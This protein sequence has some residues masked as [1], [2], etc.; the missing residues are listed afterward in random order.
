MSVVDMGDAMSLPPVWDPNKSLTEKPEA[1][2]DHQQMDDFWKGLS[3]C[4][5]RDSEPAADDPPT[6]NAGSKVIVAIGIV[7]ALAVLGKMTEEPAPE[8]SAP[9]PAGREAPSP[10]QQQA[11]PAP[12]SAVLQ[13]FPEGS[14]ALP[15]GPNRSYEEALQRAFDTVVAYSQSGMAGAR[16][17][18]ATASLAR[19]AAGPTAKRS[20]W[21]GGFRD[22]RGGDSLLVALAPLDGQLSRSVMCVDSAHGIRSLNHVSLVPGAQGVNVTFAPRLREPSGRVVDLRAL[23]QDR[24]SCADAFDALGAMNLRLPELFAVSSPGSAQ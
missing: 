1:A 12:R 11:A 2:R 10:F 18:T 6:A 15:P 16:L 3:R 14:V 20:A 4:E 23:A 7:L 17:H 13:A 19:G 24:T 22:P 9:G 8:D 21:R 5:T